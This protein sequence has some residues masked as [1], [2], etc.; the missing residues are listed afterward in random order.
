MKVLELKK[1]KKET[2]L[3][4]MLRIKKKKCNLKIINYAFMNCRKKHS[5]SL[6]IFIAII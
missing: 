6:S 4:D 2:K 3:L 5:F 1:L